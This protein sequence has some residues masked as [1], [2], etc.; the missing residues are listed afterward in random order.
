MPMC[1]SIFAD[2]NGQLTDVGAIAAVKVSADNKE[3]LYTTAGIR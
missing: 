2:G 3:T 1:V